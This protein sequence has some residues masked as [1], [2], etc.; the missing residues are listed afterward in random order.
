MYL[1]LIL[2]IS[3]SGIWEVIYILLGKIYSNNLYVITEFINTSGSRAISKTE[4]INIIFFK[5]FFI[6]NLSKFL[7]KIRAGK[8]L[9]N[10]IRKA[11]FAGGIIVPRRVI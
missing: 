1:L 9:I 11:L 10:Q 3:K 5:S 4:K 6:I 8:K 2:N 7:I